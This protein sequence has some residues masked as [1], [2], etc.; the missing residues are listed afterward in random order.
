[1]FII[2]KK[3]RL[4]LAASSVL[5]GVFTS[6]DSHA[7]SCHFGTGFTEQK[8]SV[9]SDSFLVHREMNV[10]AVI[11]TYSVNTIGIKNY[12]CDGSEKME[13][14]FMGYPLTGGSRSDDIHDAGISGIGLRMN[15][16]AGETKVEFVKTK[17]KT[18]S[19]VIVSGVI[20]ARLGGTAVYSFSLNKISFITPGCSL[21]KKNI[22]VPMGKI[23][24]TQFSGINS[25]AGERHFDID[26]TCNTDA[27]IELVLNSIAPSRVDDVLG[28]DQDSNS[29]GG[30]GL[31]VLYQDR[32]LIFNS[33]VKLGTS[34]DGIYS[35]P[36][37]ARY[38]QTENRITAGKVSATATLNIVY[39]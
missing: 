18:G 13:W 32:P 12:S 1:M 31:Q 9:S 11:G 28:L 15:A 36:F 21:G 30:I 4:L 37:K 38:I 2:H 22:F 5:I 33:P 23:G 20:T 16:Q 14:E 34:V 10:G 29:A 26:L 39:P 24:N 17:P 19:G 8:I 27:P 6:N 25:T 35:I 3:Y 7:E